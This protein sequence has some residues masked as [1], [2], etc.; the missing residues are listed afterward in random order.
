MKLLKYLTIVVLLVGLAACSVNEENFPVNLDE[1]VNNNG[2]YMRVLG[3]ESAGFDIL[4]L[5]NAAYIFTAELYDREEGDLVENVEFFVDYT[6]SDGTRLEE[7]GPFK[8]YNR[9]DFTREGSRNLP[10]NTFTITIDEVLQ[11]TGLQQDDLLIG[12]RF[13]VRWAINLTDGR[14]F[15]VEDTGPDISGGSF[16]RSPYIASVNVVA[17]IPED[18]F[19]G[20]YQFEQSTQSGTTSEAFLA[21]GTSG[22]MFNGSQTFNSDV[23][24]DPN[25]TLNGRVFSAAPFATFRGGPP[26]EDI[27]FVLALANEPENNTVTLSSSIGTGV[28]CSAIGISYGAAASASGDFDVA[29]D[30]S[31]TLVINENAAGDCGLEPVNIAFTV[32]K[33]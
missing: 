26:P 22:W 3:V 30:S 19:V 7:V 5:G 18:Q 16:F 27:P 12:D 9:G 4:D 13:R 11:A 29:D 33:N 31:F 2:A 20:N 25:N 10:R 6:S 28:S 14:S 21:F 32:T 1:V 24:V 15:S 17:A 23:V 8:T